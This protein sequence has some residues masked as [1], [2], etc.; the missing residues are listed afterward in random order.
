VLIGVA[1]KRNLG[2]ICLLGEIPIYIAHFPGHTILYPKASESIL[3]LLS[4]SLKVE[5]DLANINVYAKNV[6]MEIDFLYESLPLPIRIRVGQ[7]K[8]R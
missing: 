5:V 8:V 3:E 2:G 4:T 6:E 1:K 7:I